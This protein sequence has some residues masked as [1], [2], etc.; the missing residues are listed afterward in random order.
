MTFVVN[1][2]IYEKN[3]SFLTVNFEKVFLINFEDL[4]VSVVFECIF[5]KLS[6]E[7]GNVFKIEV[8]N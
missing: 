4:L 2:D 7:I 3:N 5:S 8:N 1:G 6:G